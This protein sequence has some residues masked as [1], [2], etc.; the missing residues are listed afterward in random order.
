M[1]VSSTTSALYSTSTSD[2][3]ASII[4]SKSPLV[5]GAIFSLKLVPSLDTSFRVIVA[6]P[7][8]SSLLLNDHLAISPTT[9]PFKIEIYLEK[10]IPVINNINKA[11]P[12][13]TIFSFSFLIK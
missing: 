6:I 3:V 10:V 8:F 5:P 9:S 7:L 4:I 12:I 11:I 2:P 1:F 13:N